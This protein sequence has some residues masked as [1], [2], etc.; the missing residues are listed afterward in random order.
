MDCRIAQENID[1]FVD[2]F[3]N[4]KDRE[5]L[6]KHAATCAV[7]QKAIDDAVRLKNAL[8]SLPEIEPPKGLAMSAIKK[9]KSKKP[10]FMYVSA[11]TAAVAAVVAL[12]VIF[13]PGI[14]MKDA[15]RSAGG[16]ESGVAA[17]KD[18]SPAAQMAPAEEEQL[19]SMEAA[20]EDGNGATEDLWPAAPEESV[21]ASI[22]DMG[23]Y[24]YATE[25]DFVT[26]EQSSYY[27]PE[28]LPQG[29]VL[30]SIS[31]DEESF[32]FSYMLADGNGMTFAWLDALDDNGLNDWLEKTYG[33]LSALNYDG[34]H[35]LYAGEG[36]TAVYW[37]QDGN[38]FHATVPASWTAQ[39]IATY[40]KAEFVEVQEPDERQ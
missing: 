4:E 12:V 21:E 27:R 40:C 28:V 2:G 34:T 6:L 17:A 22:K 1:L 15:T 5:R 39:D 37:E 7:C 24:I 38:A 36:N 30:S 11:A 33:D 18:E 32:V 29:A 20:D 13:T 10:L 14:G 31:M 19:F 16:A 3:L 25:G 26:A 35:Y 8:A 9:A 23:A